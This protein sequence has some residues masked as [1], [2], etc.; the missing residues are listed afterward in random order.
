MPDQSSPPTITASAPA[1]IL[2]ATLD[3]FRRAPTLIDLQI[4]AGMASNELRGLDL[5]TGELA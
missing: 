2:L 1:E 3:A 5:E 4:A